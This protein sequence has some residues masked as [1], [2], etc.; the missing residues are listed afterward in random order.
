MNYQSKLPINQKIKQLQA[1]KDKLA[2]KKT[3]N[4]QIIGILSLVLFLLIIAQQVYLVLFCIPWIVFFNY[5]RNQYI[6]KEKE[7]LILAKKLKNEK[8]DYILQELQGLH[9][10][11]KMMDEE[12]I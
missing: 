8:K 5:Q 1:E 9:E 10:E 6:I 7:I 2:L 12:D 3:K 4:L 11:V